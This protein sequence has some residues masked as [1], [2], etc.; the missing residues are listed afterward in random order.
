MNTNKHI[1]IIPQEHW[2]HWIE[3]EL[4]ADTVHT[5]CTDGG[6]KGASVG[7]QQQIYALRICPKSGHGNPS[8]PF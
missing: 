8:T 6:G 2:L 3:W 4:G 7:S 5:Y 1:I